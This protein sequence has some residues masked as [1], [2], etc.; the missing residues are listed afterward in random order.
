MCKM[1]FHSEGA[2]VMY[3]LYVLNFSLEIFQLG[4]FN[5]CKILFHLKHGDV[6]ESIYRGWVIPRKERSAS[7]HFVL[8]Y[9]QLFEY[10]NS[11]VND[12]ISR[13]E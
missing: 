7:S 8:W 9:C 3:M 6:K 11:P 1:W 12:K 10:C 2:K 13:N 5:M 4:I